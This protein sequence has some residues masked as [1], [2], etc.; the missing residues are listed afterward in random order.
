VSVARERDRQLLAAVLAALRA[1]A[2]RLQAHRADL[3]G[4]LPL[5][6]EQLATLGHPQLTQIE[7][8]LKKVEQMIDGFRPAFRTLLRLLGE[9]AM[10]NAAQLQVLDRLEGLGVVASAE[11][12]LDLIDLRNALTHEYPND[13]VRQARAINAA[14]SAIDELEAALER[15]QAF[16]AAQGL[17]PVS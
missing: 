11:R 13:A 9:P 6:P 8:M 1:S 4:L 12:F 14:W 17:A 16:A 3:T 5:A 10:A 2:S 15:L 7:A